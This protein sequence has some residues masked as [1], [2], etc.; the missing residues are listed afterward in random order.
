MGF[1]R[2]VFKLFLQMKGSKTRMAVLKSLTFPKDRLQLA[3]ELDCDWN[4][5]DRHIRVLFE[6]GLVREERAYGNVKFYQISA[7][8]KNLLELME[9]FQEIR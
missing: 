3:R 8:G 5:A 1:E 9:R 6:L 7:N 2:D 4:V